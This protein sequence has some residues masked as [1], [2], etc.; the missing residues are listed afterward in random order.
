MEDVI[1]IMN[2]KDMDDIELVEASDKLEKQA[3]AYIQ[4]YPKKEF[5]DLLNE[6]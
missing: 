5:E 4:D 3:M 1:Y 2:G 6:R